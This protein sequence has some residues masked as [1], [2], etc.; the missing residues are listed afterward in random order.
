M[1][2][3]AASRIKL[4]LEEALPH[5]AEIEKRNIQAEGPFL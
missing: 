1:R 3:E 4:I 2:P 5:L